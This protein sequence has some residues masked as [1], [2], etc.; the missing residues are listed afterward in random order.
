[1]PLIIP[2]HHPFGAA[3]FRTWAA[4]EG[5]A[6]TLRETTCQGAH[7]LAAAEAVAAEQLAP[8]IGIF[9]IASCKKGKMKTTLSAAL[10]MVGRKSLFLHQTRA[11]KMQ[12]ITSRTVHSICAVAILAH[13][14]CGAEASV[15]TIQWFTLHVGVAGEALYEV[16]KRGRKTSKT[17][18]CNSNIS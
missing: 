3:D 13:P 7:H 10:F 16:C 18:K 8:I 6:A 17:L 2:V 9:A 14:F 1:L 5:E 11:Y 4:R 15:V 12:T